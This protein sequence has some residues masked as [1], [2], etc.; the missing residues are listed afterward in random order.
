MKQFDVPRFENRENFGLF[1]QGLL[2]LRSYGDESGKNLPS[3]P[4]LDWHIEQAVTRLREAAVRSDTDLLSHYYLAIAVTTWNQHIYVDRLC[5][6]SKSFVALGHYL[7]LDDAR[8]IR[9][10]DTTDEAINSA[11]AAAQEALLLDKEPWPL[12]HEAV[13][14]FNHVLVKLNNFPEL[15]EESRAD[16]RH[17]AAYNLA[18]VYARLGG[19][20]TSMPPATYFKTTFPMPCP[21]EIYSSTCRLSPCALASGPVGPSSTLRQNRVLRRN[22][23]MPWPNSELIINASKTLL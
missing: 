1:V 5:D 19:R 16:L 22:W 4:L 15:T 9:N 3:K 6:C 8:R 12:L 7:G 11:K 10:Q 21:P 17:T 2:A 23:V 13:K 18:E 14:H 20:K